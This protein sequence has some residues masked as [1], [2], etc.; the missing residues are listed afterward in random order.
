MPH[1]IN[2]DTFDKKSGIVWSSKV[3]T[4][5]TKS[6]TRNMAFSSSL[7]GQFKIISHTIQ[8]LRSYDIFDKNAVL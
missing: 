4:M 2:D 7:L 6:G 5:S 3:S 1:I 8:M